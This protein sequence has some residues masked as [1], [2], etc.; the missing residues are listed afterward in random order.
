[1]CAG[2]SNVVHNPPLVN[3]SATISQSPSPRI[4]AQQTMARPPLLLPQF[5]PFPRAMPLNSPPRQWRYQPLSPPISPENQLS[6]MSQIQP[7]SPMC[8]PL[9]PR[10]RMNIS[11]QTALPYQQHVRGNMP[12]CSPPDQHPSP[13]RS[14]ISPFVRPHPTHPIRMNN[15]PMFSE[16]P[17]HVIPAPETPPQHRV[18]N[19]SQAFGSPNNPFQ[20]NF[21]ERNP[22][23][24]F[25]NPQPLFQSPQGP[26]CLPL[27]RMPIVGNNDTIRSPRVISCEELEKGESHV[28]PLTKDRTD[29]FPQES[30]NRASHPDVTAEVRKIDTAPSVLDGLRLLNIRDKHSRPQAD[31]SECFP[32]TPMNETSSPIESMELMKGNNEASFQDVL[33]HLNVDERHSS[34]QIAGQKQTIAALKQETTRSG[35]VKSESKDTED[36]EGDDFQAPP[37]V[38]N[39]AVAPKVRTLLSIKR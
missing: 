30:L 16:F 10:H 20:F 18:M 11:P 39:V 37:K 21:F 8:N 31:L 32:Q 17:P 24:F 23:M 4:L 12:P 1:M 22:N 9:P 13:I 5:P 2:I 25:N 27:T 3:P 14:P 19:V 15:Q 29:G 7:P 6:M 34:A 36:K 38:Q 33:Q 28:P 26:G 35:D